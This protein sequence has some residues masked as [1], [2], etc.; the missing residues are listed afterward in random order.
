MQDDRAFISA[1]FDNTLSWVHGNGLKDE[2]RPID[3][4]L[5]GMVTCTGA[6]QGKQLHLARH[7]SNGPKNLRGC[8]AISRWPDRAWLGPA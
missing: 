6:L 2:G 4:K 5:H 1:L 7:S 8:S 3:K